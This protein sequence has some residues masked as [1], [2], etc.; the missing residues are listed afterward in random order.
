MN[1]MT[2]ELKHAINP[3]PV[4]CSEPRRLPSGGK[5]FTFQ[6]HQPN[7]QRKMPHIHIEITFKFLC[8]H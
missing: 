2:N 1:H 7:P 4:N 8:L 3:T 6:F 5:W